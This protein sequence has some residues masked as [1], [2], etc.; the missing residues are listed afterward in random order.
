MSGI[1]AGRRARGLPTAQAAIVATRYHQA[2]LSG[3]LPRPLRRVGCAQGR[4]RTEGRSVVLCA[5]HGAEL[6]ELAAAA[7]GLAGCYRRAEVHRASLVAEYSAE[8]A[9]LGAVDVDADASAASTPG[10]AR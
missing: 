4:C 8:L 3:D 2:P 5:R 1:T 6:A 7:E 10:G 9:D